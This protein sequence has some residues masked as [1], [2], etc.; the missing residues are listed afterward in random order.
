MTFLTARYRLTRPLAAKDFEKLAHLSTVYGITGLKIDGEE[1]QVEYDAS[2]IHAAEVL[3]E[4]RAAG[5]GVA[6][7][8]PIPMGAFDYTGEFKDIPWPVAGLSP[9]N[10][11]QK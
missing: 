1:L 7:A 4:F 5:I 11:K 6:P 10:A 3:A 8:Q 9:V 2:R